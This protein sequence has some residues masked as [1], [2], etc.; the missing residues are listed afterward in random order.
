MMRVYSGP[1]Y[2]KEHVRDLKPK[3][4]GEIEEMSQVGTNSTDVNNYLCAYNIFPFGTFY[5][6][7]LALIMNIHHTLYT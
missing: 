3:F 4:W 5:F 1:T 2:D 6:R 7:M